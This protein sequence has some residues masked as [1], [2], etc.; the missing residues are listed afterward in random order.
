MKLQK[1]CQKHFSSL[2]GIPT[3]PFADGLIIFRGFCIFCS[4][5]NYTRHLFANASQPVI[6]LSRD[7]RLASR[8]RFLFATSSGGGGGDDDDDDGRHISESGRITVDT[9]GQLSI[10][11]IDTQRLIAV[12]R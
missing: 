10:R 2:Q 1:E 12:Y 7:L 8:K 5:C 6:P 3:L 9:A 4:N 11:L